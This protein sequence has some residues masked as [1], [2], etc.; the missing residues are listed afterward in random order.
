MN[1]PIT[2][3]APAK[4][5]LSGEHAVVY[6]RPALVLAVDCYARCTVTAVGQGLDLNLALP[7]L[8]RH[9]AWS[10]PQVQALHQRLTSRYGDFAAGRLPL[11]EVMG[12][13]LEMLPFAVGEWLVQARPPWPEGLRVQVELEAPLGCGMGS[14]AS[15]AL[16]LLAATARALGLNPAR[17]ELFARALAC[18][19]LCHGRPSGVDPHVCLYGGVL[20]FQEGQARP[21]PAPPWPLRLLVT[22]TPACSTGECVMQVAARFG[23]TDRIWNDFA[24]VTAALETSLA[25]HCWDAFRDATR[26]N[27]RLL[28]RI[29]VVPEP[30]A[31]LAASLDQAGFAAKVSGAGAVRGER[32]G[33]LL[34]AGEHLP[35]NFAA[36]Q[37]LRVIDIKVDHVGT[38]LL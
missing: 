15:Q 8:T 11:P 26:A 29:G 24:A 36:R 6:G 31:R 16:A 7:G 22:G 34:V 23:R 25:E 28:E 18:E 37:G 20:H 21:C 14:S 9:A 38:H 33:I 30:V 35:A 13:P 2:A 1:A 10:W 4:V 5:I 3:Q 19:R 17:A 27:Q 12:D 32:A